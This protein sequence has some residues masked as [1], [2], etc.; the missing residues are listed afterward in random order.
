VDQEVRDFLEFAGVG[1]V[2]DVV[3]AVVQVVA[4]AAHGAQAVLPAVT[5]DRA[6]DFF[7]LGPA[8]LV[9]AATASFASLMTIPVIEG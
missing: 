1:D 8:G 2:Q 3:A 9:A 5:P 6:T 7:G 4:A